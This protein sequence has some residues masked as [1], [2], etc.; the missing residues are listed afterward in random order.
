MA[1]A[2][3][4]DLIRLDGNFESTMILGAEGMVVEENLL[5]AAKTMMPPA[6][7]P[8]RRMRSSPSRMK[9]NSQSQSAATIACI[10]DRIAP[11]VPHGKPAWKT[12]EIV[13]HTHNAWTHTINEDFP[14][15]VRE[16]E[17]AVNKTQGRIRAL[18]LRRDLLK[19]RGRWNDTLGKFARDQQPLKCSCTSC[20]N[21]GDTLYR[22]LLCREGAVRPTCNEPLA[23]SQ[24][25]QSA[26]A[27]RWQSD[28]NPD[29]TSRLF[30]RFKDCSGSD[31]LAL[32]FAVLL[33]EFVTNYSPTFLKGVD[34]IVPVPADP[35]RLKERGFDPV[36]KIF[37]IFSELVCIPYASGT[38]VKEH[39]PS[40]RSMNARERE[41][42][43]RGMF[44]SVAG[45]HFS[46]LN[47]LLVDDVITSGHTINNCVALL[48]KRDDSVSI[49]VLSLFQSE[50][51]RKAAEVAS[52]DS[53]DG[54]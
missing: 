44:S 36:G 51:S 24:Q 32:F 18:Q 4:N 2:H 35:V 8:A 7:D 41:R 38:L 50:S 40:C 19:G 49:R 30:R 20:E 10:D 39:S 34:V 29:F 37:R 13:T 5:G 21:S 12:K 42:A 16:L 31:E 15:A 47:V 53:L 1:S 27:Y 11:T 52:T 54:N 43:S 6:R 9:A 45:Q 33:K 46:G 17:Q 28:T 14:K 25:H 3:R 22:S 26:F 23:F 48:R